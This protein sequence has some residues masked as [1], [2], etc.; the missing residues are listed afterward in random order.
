M[1][2]NS[3][4][5]WVAKWII[6]GIFL[7]FSFPWAKKSW[8]QSW[9]QSLV[10]N[11]TFQTLMNR[12]MNG[13]LEEGPCPRTNG[14]VQHFDQRFRF[15]FRSESRLLKMVYNTRLNDGE[16]S[17]WQ[18]WIPRSLHGLK[19]WI[20]SYKM[21]FNRAGNVRLCTCIWEISTTQ[22]EI[23]QDVVVI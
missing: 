22:V 15:T 1:P 13:I 12:L 5:P 9:E 10:A 23:G 3:R 2:T 16:F 21:K 14:L 7:K 6:L 17:G 8:M 11:Y 19:Q 4:K 20:T 18:N